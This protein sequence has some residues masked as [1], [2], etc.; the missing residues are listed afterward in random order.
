[1]LAY[2]NVSPLYFVESEPE[3]NKGYADIFLRKN[4]FT[5]DKTQHE[6]IVELKYL[7]QEDLK[8]ENSI[9]MHRKEAIGQLEK[10]AVSKTITCTLHKIILI[11]SAQEVL[12]L[13]EV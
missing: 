9:D 5:T 7:T 10:Y 8:R 3:M 13:E 6:Y 1:M 4:T 12:L 2:L 11:C